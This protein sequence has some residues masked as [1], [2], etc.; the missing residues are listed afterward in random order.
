MDVIVT[1]GDVVLEPVRQGEVVQWIRLRRGNR[2]AYEL[3]VWEEIVTIG[4]VEMAC[5]A[6]GILQGEFWDRVPD[7]APQEVTFTKPL[8]DD[9]ADGTSFNAGGEPVGP[10]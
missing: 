7:P 2:D 10:V 3:R 1:F 9:R 4:Q 8:D 5:R 6:A